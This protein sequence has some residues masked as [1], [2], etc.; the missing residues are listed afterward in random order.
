LILRESFV[1][2]LAAKL[3]FFLNALNHS[4]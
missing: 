4:P 3:L 1:V 2:A